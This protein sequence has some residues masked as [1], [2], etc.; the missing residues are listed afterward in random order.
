MIAEKTALGSSLEG[1][2]MAAAIRFCCLVAGPVAARKSRT[3]SRQL[4][5]VTGPSSYGA[6]GRRRRPRWL[7]AEPVTRHALRLTAAGAPDHCLAPFAADVSL[8][9]PHSR[10]PSPPS[11][12]IGQAL[13]VHV[14]HT[15]CMPRPEFR[16]HAMPDRT[17]AGAPGTARVPQK[18]PQTAGNA[19]HPSV[20]R[21]PSVHSQDP[22]DREDIHGQD[23]LWKALRRPG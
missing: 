16:K 22:R 3:G 14:P 1:H 21:P 6:D 2:P 19:A 12:F 5:K 10:A 8:G 18:P 11:P 4:G 7:H 17:L 20:V 23:Q 9:R 13:R 15:S